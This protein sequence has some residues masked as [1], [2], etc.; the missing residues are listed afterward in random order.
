MS[1]LKPCPCELATHWIDRR[2][3]VITNNERESADAEYQH[4]YN[5]PCFKKNGMVKPF[6]VC[7]TC[8]GSGIDYDAYPCSECRGAGGLPH[9]KATKNEA[10]RAGGEG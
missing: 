7:P 2:H 5:V 10:P 6:H 4:H 9:D 8:K 1:D 3:R